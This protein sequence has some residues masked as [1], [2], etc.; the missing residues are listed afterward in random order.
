MDLTSAAC[1]TT[2]NR[3]SANYLPTVWDYDRIKAIRSEYQGE[4]YMNRSKVLKQQLKA[5]LVERIN[6][7]VALGELIDS[8][9]RLGV[10]YHFEEEFEVALANI[11]TSG[12]IQQSWRDDLYTV[13]LAFGLLRHHGY[14]MSSDVFGGFKDEKGSFKVSV[15]GDVKGLLSLYEASHL[16]LPGEDVLDEAWAFTSRNLKKALME[17][18]EP[19]LAQKVRHSL[20]IPLHWRTIRQ[21]AKQYMGVYE[22]A[23]NMVPILLE[24][25][26]LEFNSVQCIHQENLKHMSR[27]W[28]DLGFATNLPFVRDRIVETLWCTIG[29]IFEPEFSMTREALTKIGCLM[30]SIDDVY[31]IYGSQDEL[32][33][34]PMAVQRYDN[35]WFFIPPLETLAIKPSLFFFKLPSSLVKWMR[36]TYEALFL[37]YISRKFRR[38]LKAMESL[39]DY[40]KICYLAIY[41][42]NDEISY[43]IM[44]EKG[45]DIKNYLKKMWA[46]LCKAFLV[47]AKWYKMGYTPTLD[48][49][50]SNGWISVS[51][52][53]ILVHAYFLVAQNITEEAINC[54]SND[55]NLIQWPSNYLT[56]F[57]SYAIEHIWDEIQ[58]GDAATSIQCYMHETGA[59]EELA[60]SNI[61]EL[62]RDVWK[63]LNGQCL[64]TSLF[65]KPYT[66]I[67]VNLA[68][69]AYCMYL[70]GDG[71]GNPNFDTR[72]L[73]KELLFQS[74]PTT[75]GSTA[76]VVG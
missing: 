70:Y 50:L 72:E 11:Y 17:Q 48:E 61:K 40:M 75:K 76:V 14:H 41:N 1:K 2:T 71:Y 25:A 60:R 24:F 43:N 35:I 28:T 44:K 68:R 18:L 67:V 12:N 47:E 65:P 73:V 39:P 21:E 22:Q 42:T 62:I 16:C 74:M 66:N 4:Q 64:T 20:E 23:D 27:W 53:L 13:S 15:I 34:F 9:Q 59:S 58:R 6:E 63:K 10:A 5:L 3:R 8:I 30:A 46:E 33:L 19:S 52:P 26:T 45:W 7:P 38:D 31:D 54:I 49:Y 32:E 56:K 29:L 55:Q 36:H 51:G 69:V 37:H 57:S